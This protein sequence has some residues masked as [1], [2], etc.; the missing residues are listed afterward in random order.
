MPLLTAHSA[1]ITAESS[2]VTQSELG[3][4][5]EMTAGTRIP[6]IVA[7]DHPVYR[8]GLSRALSLSGRVE[9]VEE[10]VDGAR[11]LEAVRESQPAVALVDYRMPRLDG[12]SLVRAARRDNL[13]TRVL[14]IS[15]STC[16]D[17]IG[18]ASRE[19]AAGFLGKD[20]NRAQIVAAVD[21]VHRGGLVFPALSGATD[22]A[23]AL[24]PRYGLSD[25]EFQIVDAFARGLTIPL[26]AK[27]L[28][29]AQSTAKTHTR[30]LYGKLGVGDRAAAVAEAIRRGF[31]T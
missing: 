18:V 30:R 1:A 20:M 19:G 4:G 10:C 28:S 8:E 16:R 15:A 22:A 31:L 26:A 9:V 13:A 2:M 27:E 7:D 5:V 21:A 14:L 24:C 17:V 11:A 23:P 6:V 3:R 12:I 29:I 25:R